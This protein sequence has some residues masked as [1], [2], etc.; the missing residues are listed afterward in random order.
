MGWV[1]NATAQPL[2]PRE[3]NLVPILEETGWAPLPFWTG[4]ENLARTG[5]R[6]ENNSTC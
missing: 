1:A 2:Y 5:I 4:T 3:R 6:A